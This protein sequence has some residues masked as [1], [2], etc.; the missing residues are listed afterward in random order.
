MW[1]IDI[2]HWLD[3]TKSCHAVPQL[4]L[5]VKKL[6]EIITYATSI[7][8]RMPVDSIP[9]CWRRPKRKPCKGELEIELD[10]ISGHIHWYCEVCEDEGVISGWEGLIWDMSDK[11]G[12]MHW[13]RLNR[14]EIACWKTHFIIGEST[15]KWIDGFFAV[16][17][18]YEYQGTG[19]EKA[20]ETLLAY[21]V[22]DVL[23]LEMLMV[24]AHNLKVE[25]TPFSETN[26]LSLPVMPGI[27]F[28]VYNRT[29]QRVKSR[30]FVSE[31]YSYW[32]RRG[33]HEG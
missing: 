12:K 16:L 8:S 11:P 6:T 27:P 23:N 14:R 9:K 17:L 19:N 5:K 10:K 32:W 29:V 22:E 1:V 15:L 3:E 13:C 2:N 31:E 4:R 21:N 30:F 33:K 18:W 26:Q 28:E 25:E 20:L 24:M 7:A